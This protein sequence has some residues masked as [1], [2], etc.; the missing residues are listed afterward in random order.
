MLCILCRKMKIT[1][2]DEIE[3]FDETNNV[4]IRKQN[5]LLVKRKDKLSS[6]K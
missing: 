6:N 4:K 1:N 2:L 3:N 5:F